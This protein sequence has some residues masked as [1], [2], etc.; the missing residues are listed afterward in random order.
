MTINILKIPDQYFFVWDRKRHEAVLNGINLVQRIKSEDTEESRNRLYDLLVPSVGFR[1]AERLRDANTDDVRDVLEHVRERQVQ[2]KAYLEER[3]ETAKQKA[4]NSRHEEFNKQEYNRNSIFYTIS[5]TGLTIISDAL[6]G[7]SD[8]EAVSVGM[9]S[10]E[11]LDRYIPEEIIDIVTNILPFAI[12]FNERRQ[13]LRKVLESLGIEQPEISRVESKLPNIKELNL[14]D[15]QK[16]ETERLLESY[17][18]REKDFNQVVGQLDRRFGIETKELKGRLKRVIRGSGF[19]LARALYGLRFGNIEKGV[20]SPGYKNDFYGLGEEIAHIGL[21][22]KRVEKVHTRNARYGDAIITSWLSGKQGMPTK[23]LTHLGIDQVCKWHTNH[24]TFLDPITD[25]DDETAGLYVGH[26]LFGSG[27]ISSNSR[28]YSPKDKSREWFL[29]LLEN[30][31]KMRGDI[32]ISSQTSGEIAKRRGIEIRNPDRVIEQYYVPLQFVR[33]AE[34][35][36]DNCSSPE[37]YRA[38]L[39]GWLTDRTQGSSS[40]FSMKPEYE[41]IIREMSKSVGLHM[42]DG[43]AHDKKLRVRVR[44]PEV[45]GYID[46]NS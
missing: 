3:F 17:I 37:F 40:Q 12:V 14:P 34:Y 42:S 7:K 6:L 21:D 15:E 22:E 46:P 16:Q 24:F 23:M 26:F 35:A 18:R 33:L 29:N 27:Y 28:F 31:G 44:N 9:V 2:M 8:W 38:A 19:K 41:Y 30:I 45:V 11:R 13:E 39:R 5:R 4:N 20:L 43:F 32:S 10:G 1:E 25:I 36:L